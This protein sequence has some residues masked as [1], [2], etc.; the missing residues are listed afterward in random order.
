MAAGDVT[1][2][3]KYDGQIV[4][5]HTAGTTVYLV[6]KNGELISYTISGAATATVAHLNLPVSCIWAD[7]TY[8]YIGTTTGRFVR[9]TIA[10][11]ANSKLAKW[12]SP[13]TSI[14]LLSTLFYIGL[15]DGRLQS[16]ATA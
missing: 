1:A 5:M 9:Y 8:I 13:I 3:K 11:G 15:A 4:A 14:C 6:T 2:L 10:T 16:Y 7:A 12:D